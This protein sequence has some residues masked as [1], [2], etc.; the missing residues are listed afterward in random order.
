MP[1]ASAS[2]VGWNKSN[3]AIMSLTIIFPPSS[4]RIDLEGLVRRWAPRQMIDDHVGRHRRAV[5]QVSAQGIGDGRCDGGGPGAQHRFADPLNPD[6]VL[7]IGLFDRSPA[8]LDRNIEIG[9]QLALV[10]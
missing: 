10:E 6:G 2:W 8:D 5:E 9:G 4:N 1:S 3:W 7:R